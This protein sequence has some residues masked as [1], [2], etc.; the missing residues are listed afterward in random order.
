MGGCVGTDQGEGASV[1]DQ[2]VVIVPSRER[3]H[4]VARLV[5]AWIETGAEAH[6]QIGVD[7]DENVDAYCEALVDLG[8]GG[9]TVLPRT[10]MT[11]TLNEIA[12]E[13]ADHYR[14]VGFMGDDHLP[15]TMHWDSRI[16]TRLSEGPCRIVYGNDLMQ[17]PLLPTAVFM[18]SRIIRAL[19][20]M[21]PPALRHLFLDNTWRDWGNALG[22][23]TYLPDV[24][25]EHMHPQAGKAEN[26]EGYGRVNAADIWDHDEKA[27]EAYKTNGGQHRDMELMRGAMV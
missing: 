24:I 14:Y 21:A 19:G 5:K 20:Y 25:I 7:D 22:T 2:M 9:V 26:D 16:M 17:G 27:Y 18:D 4:N 10:G 11:G 8:Q 23:L 6:L 15:R 3:P 12:V 1:N 13:V